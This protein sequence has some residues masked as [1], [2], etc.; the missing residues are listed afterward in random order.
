MSWREVVLIAFGVVGVAWWASVAAVCLVGVD[1]VGVGL[2]GVGV[3]LVGVGVVGVFGVGVGVGVG[4]V[5]FLVIAL[6]S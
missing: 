2:V 1:L 3:G 6:Q 5:H 4:V